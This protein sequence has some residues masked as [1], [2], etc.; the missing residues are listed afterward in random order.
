MFSTPE[1]AITWGVRAAMARLQAEMAV[2]IA[3]QT[4]AKWWAGRD[5]LVRAWPLVVGGVCFAVSAAHIRLP[6]LQAAADFEPDRDVWSRDGHA[7]GGTTAV[8]GQDW[9]QDGRGLWGSLGSLFADPVGEEGHRHA[10]EEHDPK[11]VMY[12]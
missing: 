6:P 2:K 1:T 7:G 10:P 3:R 8:G 5:R 12:Y 4:L 9:G 11:A